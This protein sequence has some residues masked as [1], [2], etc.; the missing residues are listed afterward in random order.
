MFALARRIHILGWEARGRSEPKANKM[1]FDGKE[2]FTEYKRENVGN[3]L[4]IPKL[5]EAG[6]VR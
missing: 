1:I 3:N 5:T 6:G 2:M 4:Y